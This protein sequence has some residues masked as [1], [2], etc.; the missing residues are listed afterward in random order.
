MKKKNRKIRGLVCIGVSLMVLSMAVFANYDNAGGYAAIK[1]GVKNLLYAD[2]YT[3]NMTM[4]ASFDGMN[5][6]VYDGSVKVDKNGG[7]KMQ[8]KMDYNTS[9]G[10]TSSYVKTMQDGYMLSEYA[11][12]YAG[13]EPNT[14]TKYKIP[15]S[16]EQ[17]F[18]M[19]ASR[20][21]EMFTKGVNL[22]EALCDTM[23][24]DVKNNIVLAQTDGSNRTYSLNMT[25]EQLPSYVSAGFSFMCAGIR[26][27]NDKSEIG[28][29]E[30]GYAN[31]LDE[32]FLNEKEPYV[33]SV[34]GT[35]TVDGEDRVCAFEGK[36]II[37]GYDSTGSPKN[38]E[39][40]VDMTVDDFGTTS[41]ER[42]N[43]DDYESVPIINTYEV[44]APAGEAAEAYD[45]VTIEI[46]E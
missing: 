39:M 44:D 26:M 38:I 18:P 14:V 46:E 34:S 37:T 16:M 21:N 11:E 10:Y 45:G 23:V 33:S 35:V 28:G 30:E 19:V 15:S 17:D 32:M 6:G 2:N 43:L 42:E 12:Q 36:L 8:Y 20:D 27:N 41:I 13:G 3:V 4:G 29:L 31:M 22:V 7:V 5:V 24:G 9:W 1:D 25:G 40:Y